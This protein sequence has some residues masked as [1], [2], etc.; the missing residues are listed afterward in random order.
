M[1]NRFQCIPIRLGVCSVLDWKK[2]AGDSL[3]LGLKDSSIN[4][5]PRRTRRGG[6][7]DRG[8]NKGTGRR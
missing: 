7:G 4:P 1:L 3:I 8:G 2:N 6:R 5:I